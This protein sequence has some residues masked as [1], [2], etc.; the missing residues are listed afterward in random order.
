M[1][2]SGLPGSVLADLYIR[3]RDEIDS[4][5]RDLDPNHKLRA[6][7]AMAILAAAE[8]FGTD[9]LGIEAHVRQAFGLTL[10]PHEETIA[11]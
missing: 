1:N 5:E 8:T 3:L 11:A 10:T 4:S 7:I 9:V 2:T 6:P